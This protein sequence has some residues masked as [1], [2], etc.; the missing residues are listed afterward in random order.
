MNLDLSELT[1]CNNKCKITSLTR[2]KC[3]AVEKYLESKSLFGFINSLARPWL[4]PHGK[5]FRKGVKFS[6][7]INSFGIEENLK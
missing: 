3:K 2:L 4:F 6:V 5:S 1:K 7:Q